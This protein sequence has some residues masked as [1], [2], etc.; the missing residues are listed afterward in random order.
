[1]SLLAGRFF[2]RYRNRLSRRKSVSAKLFFEPENY[3]FFL[4]RLKTALE[5]YGPKLICYCLMPNHFHL[6]LHETAEGAIPDL[7]MSLQISYA[8]AINKRYNRVGHLFQRLFKNI[9]IDRDAY[10]LHLLRYNSIT[11]GLVRNAE[12]WEYS[13]TRDFIAYGKASCRN[14]M[15]SSRSSRTGRRTAVLSWNT[16]M[17]QIFEIK[18]WNEIGLGK[19]GFLKKRGINHA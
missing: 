7:V 10:L 9:Y 13:R 18:H 12:D 1:M 19:T 5:K 17:I 8:K 6:I 16:K 14:R 11:A 2:K 15:S 4:R 3:L